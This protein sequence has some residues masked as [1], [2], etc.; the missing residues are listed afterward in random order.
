MNNTLFDLAE[1]IEDNP[2]GFYTIASQAV[3]YTRLRQFILD[4]ISL[5][6]R[7]V[8][9]VI[10]EKPDCTSSVIELQLNLNRHHLNNI[11]HLLLKLKLVRRVARGGLYRYKV[12]GSDKVAGE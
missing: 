2:Y 1:L 12:A 10:K 3:S 9:D 5:Q 4:H 7:K 11:L 8:Y 6:Q